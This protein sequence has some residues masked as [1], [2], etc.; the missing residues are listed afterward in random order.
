M[1]KFIYSSIVE[2]LKTIENEEG[3]QAIKHFDLWNNQIEYIDEE[4][5]F[6]LPAVFLEF[7][8]INWRYQANKLYTT[9]LVA[10][11]VHVVTR[12][13][14]PTA[15]GS[16]YSEAGLSFFDLID[17]VRRAL[18]GYSHTSEIGSHGLLYNVQ[19]DTD[20]DAGELRNDVEVFTCTGTD[21][22]LVAESRVYIDG[23]IV[24]RI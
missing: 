5:P 15:A 8:S 10:V 3:E 14:M 24:I 4:Q 9:D 12:R 1:R 7:Q 20:A 13:A 11:K 6:G 23:R 16:D 2:R 18:T 22:S 19:S 17:G 21:R